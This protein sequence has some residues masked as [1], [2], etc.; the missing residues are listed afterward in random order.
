M[1][2]LIS[3]LLGDASVSIYNK[4][5]DLIHV[6]GFDGKVS[7]GTYERPIPVSEMEYGHSMAIHSGVFEYKVSA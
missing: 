2:I 6:E 3:K 1:R 5:G 7:S 4:Q